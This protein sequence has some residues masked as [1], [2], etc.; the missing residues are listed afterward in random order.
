[1]SQQTDKSMYFARLILRGDYEVYQAFKAIIAIP[2]WDE[3]AQQW[4]DVHVA[5]NKTRAL[6]AGLNPEQDGLSDLRK[7]DLDTVD[8]QQLVVE[9]LDEREH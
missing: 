3:D 4:T 2:T 8:Y 6:L 5:V 9:E 1:M 7:I